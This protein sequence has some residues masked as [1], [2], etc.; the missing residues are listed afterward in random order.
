MR[1]YSIFTPQHGRGWETYPHEGVLQ[2]LSM[3]VSTFRKQLM[4]LSHVVSFH[5]LSFLPR[6]TKCFFKPS[7]QLYYFILS[8]LFTADERRPSTGSSLYHKVY[9]SSSSESG[10]DDSESEDDEDDQEESEEESDEE[11]ESESESESDDES[12]SEC[13]EDEGQHEDKL[14]AIKLEAEEKIERDQEMTPVVVEKEQ[15]EFILK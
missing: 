15:G 8:F 2:Y 14:K 7:K 1:V 9:S 5:V 10:S 6:I 11:S 13:E 3:R 4:M 12:E